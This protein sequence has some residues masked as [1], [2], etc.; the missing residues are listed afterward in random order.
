M[1]RYI[2][3]WEALDLLWFSITDPDAFHE[4]FPR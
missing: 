1:L 3:F 2:G 4:I